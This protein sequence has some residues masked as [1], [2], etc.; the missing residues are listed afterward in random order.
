MKCPFCQ[1]ENVSGTRFCAECGFSMHLKIC[2]NPQCG[3]IS[4]VGVAVC[5]HCGETFPKVTV[6]PEPATVAPAASPVPANVPEN[7]AGSAARDKPRTAAWPLIMVAVV[8]GGLPLLWANRASL[9]TPKT[10]QSSTQDATKVEGAAPAPIGKM[11][12]P[13]VPELTPAPASAPIQA[14]SQAPADSAGS[15]SPAPAQAPAAGNVD[16]GSPKPDPAGSAKK[17]PAASQ[18]TG[19]S[20]KEVAKK[21]AK[22]PTPKKQEPPRPCT[23]AT[24][25]LGLCD[26]KRPGQ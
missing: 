10:W 12:P 18:K 19:G 6:A 20:T 13:V 8:A 3:K 1:H 22:P 23:E 7:A 16:Q 21:A 14:P 2:P 17:D 25:A 5:E 15:S 9:P 26:P 4:D 11:K 24:A